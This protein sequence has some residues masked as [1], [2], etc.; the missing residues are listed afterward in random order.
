M[1]LYITLPI[2]ENGIIVDPNMS[3]VVAEAIAVDPFGFEDV[4]IY[5]HGWSTNAASALDE[6]ALFMVEFAKHALQLARIDPPICERT[7]GQSLG[8]GIHWP[9]EITEDGQSP[10]NALQLLTFYTMEHRAD[11]VGTNAVYMLVRLI[12]AARAGSTIPLRLNFLGHSFGTKVVLAA[13]QAVASDVSGGKIVAA[14]G[15]QFNVVLLESATDNDNLDPGDIY[16]AVAGIPNLRLLLTTSQAD[17]A[18]CQWFVVAGKLANL[19]HAPRRALGDAGPTPATAAAFGGAA[20]VSIAPGFDGTQLH[21]IGE[22]LIVADLTPVH[23]AR[24]ASGAYS[25]GGITGSHSD[26]NFIE[27]YEL[28]GAFLFGVVSA[29]APVHA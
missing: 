7:P 24:V 19:L 1:S 4:Y 25:T 14:P 27:L 18:L 20:A 17:R 5:S 16:G 11:S 26:I 21:G 12:L 2:N 28:V 9:S 13:L 29:D 6:Y 3:S 22:R 15:T 8:V 10:L 23:R